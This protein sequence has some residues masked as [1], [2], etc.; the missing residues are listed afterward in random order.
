MRPWGVR[1]PRGE[2]P[3]SSIRVSPGGSG[4]PSC[5]PRL[6]VERVSF[7]SGGLANCSTEP[8]QNR[9]I[10]SRCGD[11]PHGADRLPNAAPDGFMTPFAAGHVRRMP[12]LAAGPF[13]YRR[14][15]DEYLDTTLHGASQSG[16]H[17][18]V[19]PQPYVPGRRDP[20]RPPRAV[21]RRP[22]ARGRGRSPRL[23]AQGRAQGADQLRQ[24]AAGQL[25][26][27]GGLLSSFIDL[28]N[29][30]LARFS[31]AD[32]RR[33][34]V[35]TCP[36]GDRDSTHIADA[37]C[38]DLLPALFQLNAGNFC[39]TLAGDPDRTRVLAI[40]RGRASGCSSDR[41]GVA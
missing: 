9:L 16:G 28:N 6:G 31:A 34:G 7:L 27:T 12:R 41:Y 39:V 13:R 25:D 26:P 14:Q 36:G 40:I 33:I 2:V 4:A 17:L 11:N 29:L 1:H 23:P 30:A 21:H 20:R 32:R 37:D 5:G 19:G 22:V 38:A 18:A 24:G 15:A 35:H 8:G 3:A 10:R